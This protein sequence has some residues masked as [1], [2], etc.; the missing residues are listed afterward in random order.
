MATG[1]ISQVTVV[2]ID[3]DK[4]NSPTSKTT[5]ELLELFPETATQRTGKGGYHLFY[6][7]S[8]TLKNSTGHFH[9]QVDI[10]TSGGYIVL[11][12]SI[13]PDTNKPYEWI[14]TPPRDLSTL[15]DTP[16][17]LLHSLTPEDTATKQTTDF[18]SLF[19]GSQNGKRNESAAKVIG[20]L[21]HHLSYC[22]TPQTI[23]QLTQAWNTLN[24]PP[25][26]NQELERTFKSII[27][28]HYGG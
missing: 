13:H 9:P 18:N 12:P 11:A 3:H 20:K 8:P 6:K 25:L 19:Q 14:K 17:D 24:K 22:M 27:Q 28:K 4:T 16:L 2:D 10:K 1:A 23:W 15:P 26:P 7:Y 21:L 5:E